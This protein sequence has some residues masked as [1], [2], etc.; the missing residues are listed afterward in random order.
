MPSERIALN[1]LQ[2][3]V[4]F[5]RPAIVPFYLITALQE[6]LVLPQLYF[7]GLHHLRI[8]YQHI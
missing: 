1:G 3:L 5:I 2:I 6:L 4:H 8:L 7:F